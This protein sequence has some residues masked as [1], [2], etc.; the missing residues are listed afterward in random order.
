MATTLSERKYW[1]IRIA[2][3]GQDHTLSM[4]TAATPED[5]RLA[6]SSVVDALADGQSLTGCDHHTGG[7]MV[8]PTREILHLELVWYPGP[9]AEPNVPDGFLTDPKEMQQ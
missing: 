3:K 2:V 7:F 8:I 5:M 9:P 6:V 1:A 4:D